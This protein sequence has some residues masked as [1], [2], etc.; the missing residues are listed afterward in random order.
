MAEHFLYIGSLATTKTIKAVV[1]NET[2]S[3]ESEPHTKYNIWLDDS[4]IPANPAAFTSDGE[5]IGVVTYYIE[6]D[7]INYEGNR[8]RIASSLTLLIAA[9]SKSAYNGNYAP[10]VKDAIGTIVESL[11]ESPWILV[12]ERGYVEFPSGSPSAIVLPLNITFYKYTGDFP[13]GGGPFLNLNLSDSSN[14]LSLGSTSG[15]LVTV[16]AP[17]PASTIT[18][19]MPDVGVSAD[20]L[21]TAGDQ[22]STGLKTFEDIK[23]TSAEVTTEDRRDKIVLNRAADNVHQVCGL[24]VESNAMQYSVQSTTYEHKFSSATSSTTSQELLTISGDQTGIKLHKGNYHA[25]LEPPSSLSENVIISIPSL[26][27]TMLTEGAVY[28]ESVSVT[29]GATA[30]FTMYWQKI[31]PLTFMTF[32]TTVATGKGTSSM[33]TLLFSLGFAAFRPLS[34]TN[35]I[36][37]VNDGAPGFGYMTILPAGNGSIFKIPV[38]T[39]GGGAIGLT[40]FT[41]SYM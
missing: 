33:I 37:L 8:Y 20:F 12:H 11:G 9:F 41:T 26:S 5:T 1:D 24:G 30:V 40:G 25:A 39:F 17:T 16:S 31:G 19:T 18:Y 2:I 29:G 38:T 14:Q 3:E 32:P 4:S 35:I 36:I 28:S 21:L 23:I 22:T 15:A 27:G 7:L 6:R 13:G 34:D 10:I